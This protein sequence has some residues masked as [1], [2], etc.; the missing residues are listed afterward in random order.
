MYRLERE[1]FLRSK[2]ISLW[3]TLGFQAGFINSFAFLVG[4]RYVSHV[5]GFGTQVGF[6]LGKDEFLFSAELLLIPVFFILGSFLSG[7][8]TSARIERKLKPRYELVMLAMP[9]VI[10]ILMILALYGVFGEFGA[11]IT[12]IEKAI[13]SLCLATLCGLQNGCFATMTKGQIRTTHLTGISTDLGTDLAKLFF[14]KLP[15]TEKQFVNR[16]NFC[17]IS[18]IVSFAIG[19]VASAL[20][21]SSLGYVALL[22]PA[23]LSIGICYAVSQ[24]SHSIDL[25]DQALELLKFPAHSPQVTVGSRSSESV[26]ISLH[27]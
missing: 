27:I 8:L 7:I 5:T 12:S 14:G 21:S 19:A 25:R 2:Y 23:V 18:T 9:I 24:I 10:L 11:S 4:E 6:A 20:F 17:R 1:E 16:I 13:F 3:S 22:V 26:E 15:K